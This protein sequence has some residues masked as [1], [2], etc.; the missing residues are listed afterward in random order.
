MTNKTKPIPPI[1]QLGAWFLSLI[2]FAIGFWHTHLGLKQMNLFESKYG[3][4]AIAAVVLIFILISYWFAVNRRSAVALIFYI[5]CGLFVFIFNLNYIYPAYMGRN[6]V[7]EEAK[8]INDTLQSYANRAQA[9]NSFGSLENSDF[10]T[11]ENLIPS[12]LGEVKNLKGVGTVA[13][14]KIGE[15]NNLLGKFGVKDRISISGGVGN[16]QNERE[17]LATQLE[18][19]LRNALGSVEA[20]GFGGKNAKKIV[21]GR[22]KLLKLQKDYATIIE[23]IQLD[24]SDIILDSVKNHPQINSLI[25]LTKGIDEA[26][27]SINEGFGTKKYEALDSKKTPSVQ[28]LGQVEHTIQTINKRIDRISTWTIILICLFIDLMVPLAMYVLLRKKGDEEDNNKLKG[29]FRP[30]NFNEK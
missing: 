2:V 23:E 1:V 22:D 15:F 14:N 30:I 19:D 18:Q 16:T 10:N 29:R 7:N 12:I 6:L 3:T 24:K 26:T 20:L 11:L 28:F 13:M 21:E 27:N 9:D 5:I 4:I 25:S 17:T 8:T